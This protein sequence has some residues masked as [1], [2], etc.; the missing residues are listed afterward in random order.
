M[1]IL[2]GPDGSGKTTL[3]RRLSELHGIPMVKRDKQDA[4]LWS[5][6]EL[7]SWSLSGLRIYDR[8]ALVSEYIYGPLRRKGIQ[9]EF[10]LGYQP[11]EEMMERF[12]QDSLII[13]CRPPTQTIVRNVKE[14]AQPQD[15]QPITLEVIKAYDNWFSHVPHKLFDYI[16]DRP[17]DL[18]ELIHRHRAEWERT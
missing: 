1:I 14:T 11:T 15:I 7:S 4:Y 9:P 8:F 6:S 12:I 16:T 2:E 18:N 17:E 10:E 3:G 5:M 13:Y